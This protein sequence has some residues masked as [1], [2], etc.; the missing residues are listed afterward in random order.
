MGILLV[1]STSCHVSLAVSGRYV[2]SSSCSSPGF[3]CVSI[4]LVVITGEAVLADSG[5]TSIVV[6]AAI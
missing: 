6:D 5:N 1:S 4:A 2:H 3:S